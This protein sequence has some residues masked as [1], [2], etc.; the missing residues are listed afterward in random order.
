M[1]F[2]EDLRRSR[3]ALQRQAVELRR[4]QKLA[5]LGTWRWLAGGQQIF[6]SEELHAIFGTQPDGPPPTRSRML[7]MIHPED[8]APVEATI[9]RIAQ[10]A[11]AAA[12]SGRTGSS[13]TAAPRATGKPIS[14]ATKAPCTA[15]SRT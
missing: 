14:T 7:A 10:S 4:T 3:Q 13:S 11:K 12:C 1:R 8:R 6:W 15:T 9:T 5:R 2:E